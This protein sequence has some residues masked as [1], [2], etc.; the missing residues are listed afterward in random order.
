MISARIHAD[1]VIRPRHRSSYYI[2]ILYRWQ[3]YL[4]Y[5]YRSDQ[6]YLG[7][8]RDL[9]L[10]S[11]FEAENRVWGGHSCMAYGSA[12]FYVHAASLVAIFS[13]AKSAV[14]DWGV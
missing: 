11:L 8:E 14:L 13:A 6:S 2:T 9:A 5:Q 10:A 4:L 12:A 7:M 1:V 3:R